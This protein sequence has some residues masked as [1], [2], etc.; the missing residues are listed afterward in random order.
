ML[1][2]YKQGNVKNHSVGMQYVKLI[3][4]VNDED[5]GAEFEAWEKYYP[6]IA[7]KAEAD[8]H[9]YFWAVKEAKV[10][11]GSAVPIGSNRATPTL[12]IKEAADSTSAEK[13]K[14]GSCGE[15]GKEGSCGEKD[16]D[17][18]G[19]CGGNVWD[20][21]PWVNSYTR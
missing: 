8:A 5:Y 6:L 9:G 10:I 17:K 11:E 16:K 20:L 19:S 15:K 13:G 1:N 21:T 12:D 3:M 7:N 4:A 2:Q 14:E 18:E